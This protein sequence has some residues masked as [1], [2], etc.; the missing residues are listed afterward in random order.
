MKLLESI[1]S[2]E[3]CGIDIS[4]KTIDIA[5]END[6]KKLVRWVRSDIFQL[7]IV[8]YDLVLTIDIIDFHFNHSYFFV[9]LCLLEF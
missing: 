1:G 7:N 6:Q 8:E 2:V 5:I 3:A 4:S 9:Y